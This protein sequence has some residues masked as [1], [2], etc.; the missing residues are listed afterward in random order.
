MSE[1]RH[2]T[3][4]EEEDLK[5]ASTCLSQKKALQ[6]DI[7][8]LSAKSRYG[9]VMRHLGVCRDTRVGFGPRRGRS[10][11]LGALYKP[12]AGAR[13][14]DSASVGIARRKAR[15]QLGVFG[16]FGLFYR[17]FWL[18]GNR[19]WASGGDRTGPGRCWW[20]IYS[21]TGAHVFGGERLE[22][23]RGHPGRE[24]RRGRPGPRAGPVG[25]SVA[26][27]GTRRGRRGRVAT[28]RGQ[29]RR[30]LSDVW[31][32]RAPRYLRFDAV[33]SAS[34]P[35]GFSSQ[36]DRKSTHYTASYH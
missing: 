35:S 1:E 28:T 21:E 14:L 26:P 32:P 10:N 29:G 2:N 4:V 22:P 23:N 20:P 5:S 15:F 11:A 25:D 16:V 30:R 17:R 18:A 19:R 24:V 33:L 34:S 8:H 3:I 31:G 27:L 7:K 9:T 6:N 12:G 36:P 13:F